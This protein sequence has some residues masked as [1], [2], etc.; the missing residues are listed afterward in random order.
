MIHA[1]FISMYAYVL[2]LRED[3][4]LQAKRYTLYLHENSSLEFF[5][6]F[7]KKSKHEEFK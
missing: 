2:H 6:F 1:V 3:S 7:E 5:F 4:C